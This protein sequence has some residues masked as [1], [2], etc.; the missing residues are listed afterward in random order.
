M[1]SNLESEM[2]RFDEIES[3]NKIRNIEIKIHFLLKENILE[4]LKELIKIVLRL[5]KLKMFQIMIK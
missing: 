4:E 3:V 2:K 5:N 1:L